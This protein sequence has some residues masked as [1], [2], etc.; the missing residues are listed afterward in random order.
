MSLTSEEYAH[1]EQN[2]IEAIEACEVFIDG[3]IEDKIFE[4][5]DAVI[6]ASENDVCH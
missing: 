2:I 4:L 3:H 5:I 1:L 6:I